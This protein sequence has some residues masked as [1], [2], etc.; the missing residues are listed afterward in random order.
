M[1]PERALLLLL[2]VLVLLLLMVLV[3]LLLRMVVVL[4]VMVLVLLLL[5][6]VMLLLRMVLLLLM[7]VRA[8]RRGQRLCVALRGARPGALA[9]A[10]A[11]VMRRAVSAVGA[12]GF[13]FVE[14]GHI[15]HG[16]AERLDH[17]LVHVPVLELSSS[18]AILLL[19]AVQL[20]ARSGM[21]RARLCVHLSVCTCGLLL[22][23]KDRGRRPGR[24]TPS[25]TTTRDRARVVCASTTSACRAHVARVDV[26][27]AQIGAVRHNARASLLRLLVVSRQLAP[28]AVPAAATAEA[29]VASAACG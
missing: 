6:V 23:S 15:G 5:R 9:V 19:L 26:A 28:L 1:L 24:A 8:V 27:V 21:R 20:P 17:R 2:L 13:G 11:V 16:A 3:L 4:L 10:L 18:A 12:F 25:G 14:H 22:D 7:L 29:A